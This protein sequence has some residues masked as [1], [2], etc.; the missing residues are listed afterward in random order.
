VTSDRRLGRRG[1]VVG[2]AASVA[3]LAVAALL[4]WLGR[5]GG[6]A[7]GGRGD[8]PARSVS[9]SAPPAADGAAASEG[10]AAGAVGGGGFARD[11]AGAAEAALAYTAAAQRWLYLSED[12]VAEAVA[13]IAAP[14]SAD[15]LV[16]QVVEETRPTRDELAQAQG[17]VW[18]WVHPLAWRVETYSDSRA[19]V[20][21][22]TLSVLS[23]AGVAVPQS[24]W[25]TVTVDL[26]WVEDDWR[27]AA[28]RDRPG[29]TPMTGP[30]DEPW[31]A[32]RFADA[33]DG[34]SRLGPQP[35]E[36]PS[37][38]SRL[39]DGIGDGG[40][41]AADGG[42]ARDEW[43]AV[44]AALAYTAASQRWLYLPDRQV[45]EAVAQIAAPRSADTLV[46]EA[47]EE[48]RTARDE[49]AKSEGPVWWWVHPL[50]WRVETYSDSR[51]SVAVWTLSV[52]SA[53]GVAVPQSEWMT[54]TVDLEW[55]E[56]D[57]RVAAMRDRPGPTPIASP[58][59]EPWDATPF[60]ETLDGFTRLG[61]EP[62]A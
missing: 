55:V 61:E 11:E 31:D 8:A 62:A 24:E 39:P 26:E 44:E 19:S 34:F 21:V 42:F 36:G 40:P 49:L 5:P 57:W 16:A 37:T 33:L 52:L 6:T 9:S 25:M 1:L 2:L 48:T 43:G 41:G 45:A 60:A 35:G 10:G 17:P 27:V 15:A 53:T 38:L 22:W 20:A 7:A 18:W 3:L 14:R 58:R 30:R 50:A 32:V 4:G 56:D 23:A 59:D 51:A 12:Q 46:A 28:M 29:P 47:V 13:Q 54:V